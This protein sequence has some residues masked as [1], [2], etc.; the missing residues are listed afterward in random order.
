MSRLHRLASDLEKLLE[1]EY[2]ALLCGDLNKFEHLISEKVVLLEA[3][4]M[5]K[6]SEIEGFESIRARLVRN[7]HLAQSAIKGMRHA[8]RR[9]KDIRDVSGGLRTYKQ[10]GQGR[11]IAARSN[12]GLFKRS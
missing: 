7:Q 5:L 3:V 8:I 12:E 10:N 2:K 11:L 6:G 1:R 9:A 4:G